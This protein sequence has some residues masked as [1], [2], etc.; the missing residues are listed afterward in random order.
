MLNL[1]EIEQAIKDLENSPTT[2]NNCMKLASLYIVR[3]TLRKEG[4]YSNYNYNYN[5]NYP[6]MYER[7]GNSGNS[8]QNSN[9]GSSSYGYNEMPMM[10]HNDDDLLI[11][12]DMMYN[13]RG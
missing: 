7:G 11:R 12:K 13:R 9:S 6:M 5:K 4:Q 10:Y 3:D 8:G 2:Y 1:R